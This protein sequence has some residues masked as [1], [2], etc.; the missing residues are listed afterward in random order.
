MLKHV[1]GIDG[2]RRERLIRVLD[3]DPDWQ[4]NKV[5][6]GQRRRVQIAMGLLR[7]FKVF[8][9]IRTLQCPNLLLHIS[10]RCSD[11]CP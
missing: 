6:D 8:L 10:R 11:V 9:S 2:A 1:P 5:S 7:P 4:M 3:I